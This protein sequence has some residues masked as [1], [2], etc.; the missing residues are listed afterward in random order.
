MFHISVF[1]S[2]AYI[3]LKTEFMFARQHAAQITST[4]FY[5]LTNSLWQ[6]FFIFRLQPL[7]GSMRFNAIWNLSQDWNCK[8]ISDAYWVLLRE[9][10]K[11][12]SLPLAIVA[13]L[14]KI[15]CDARPT[16]EKFPLD[17]AAEHLSLQRKERIRRARIFL[18]YF[19][20]VCYK[21]YHIIHCCKSGKRRQK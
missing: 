15:L 8:Y 3:R 10:E 12:F 7:N 21:K 18:I 5:F 16:R 20:L 9:R 19:H 11:D 14:V 13:Q 6:I 17:T 1:T 2:W 4:H